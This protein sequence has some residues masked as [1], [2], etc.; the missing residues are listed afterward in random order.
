MLHFRLVALI[1]YQKWS[2]VAR[3]LPGRKGKQ[4]R[5]RWHN[6]LRK[7]IKKGYWSEAEEQLF[8]DAHRELGNQWAE[9]ARRL[10]GRSE[11][12]VKNHFNATLRRKVSS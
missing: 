12:A 4:C 1:G 10:H 2:I 3:H 6:H 7:D 9:I 11:N 5:E 8:V